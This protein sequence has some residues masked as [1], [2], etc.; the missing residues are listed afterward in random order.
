MKI[1]IVE[2]EQELARNI[3][4]YLTGE[5][6]VCE[7]ATSY[8]EAIAKTD[9]YTYECILLDLMLPGGSGIQV[10]EFLKEQNKLDGVIIISAKDSISDK[11]QGLQL[12]ADDYLAKPFHLAELSARVFSVIRR[13]KFNNANILQQNELQVDLLSKSS[14]LR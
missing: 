13:R 1:L 14:T 4:A 7:I 10:L 8:Y 2:D 5:S 11:I 12:G 3:S 9:L 6:Y